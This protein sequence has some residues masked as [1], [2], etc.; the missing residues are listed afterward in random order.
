MI[1]RSI[2]VAAAAL[3]VSG[4]AHA[5]NRPPAGPDSAT[6]RALALAYLRVE[7][8]NR[9]RSINSARDGPSIGCRTRP[10]LEQFVGRPRGRRRPADELA[11]ARPVDHTGRHVATSD[12]EG[13]YGFVRHRQIIAADRSR[14]TPASSYALRR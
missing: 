14:G 7:L 11:H 9:D 13:K 5:Q 6:R 1:L 10:C 2:Y 3:L 4:T 8:A 12:V